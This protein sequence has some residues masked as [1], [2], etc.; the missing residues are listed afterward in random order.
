M[1]ERDGGT[2]V[3]AAP[4]P[5]A[6]GGAGAPPVAVSI[7][8][9]ATDTLSVHWRKKYYRRVIWK[10]GAALLLDFTLL[11]FVPAMIYGLAAS[12][13]GTEASTDEAAINVMVIARLL[14][15]YFL[16]PA[17]EA[18]RWCAT[19]GK[20]ILK[21]Q[22]TDRAGRISYPRAFLRNILRTLTFY[23]YLLVIPL[24]IQYFRFQTTKK[25]FHDELTT[26]VID[27]R[28]PAPTVPDRWPS[29]RGS[30]RGVRL[31]AQERPNLQVVVDAAVERTRASV[32]RR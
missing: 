27:D 32:L 14:A 20:R 6:S 24:V 2:G 8:T 1:V 22:I 10:R 23:S 28:L 31:T 13:V 12:V 30:S 26:T 9:P 3:W 17:M 29:A 4:V 5:Q 16:A 21:L 18:S 15:F 7:A 11:F 19:P 25:L